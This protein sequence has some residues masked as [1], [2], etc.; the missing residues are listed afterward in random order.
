MSVTSD[1]GR[2]LTA[3]DDR[4]FLEAA[5]RLARKHQGLT[6]T[7]PSVSCLVVQMEEHGP[8]IVG[9][10]VTAIGG[11][12][13]AEP[14][15]LVQ[16][17]DRAAGATAYVTL[18]PCAHHGKTPPCAQTLID[19]KISRVVTAIGDPDRR[20]DGLGH[21]ILKD[22]GVEVTELDC[23]DLAARVI[24]GYLSWQRVGRPYITLKMAVTQ[25]GV[26]GSR[27]TGN[28]R[29]SGPVA[30]AQT[31]L[32]R[33]RS[34]AILIG[35]GT[36]VSD[37]PVL[38]CRLPGLEHRS[39]LRIVLDS[40]CKMTADLR[41]VKSAKE[42]ATMVVS[43]APADSGWKK[44]LAALGVV[45]QAC[46]LDG[47]HIALP[48]LVDD[49]G[50]QGIQTLLIEGGAEVA[51]SFLQENLVDE[52]L[53]HVGGAPEAEPDDADAVLAPFKPGMPPPG[54]E[55]REELEFGAD[56][57]IRLTREQS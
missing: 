33:A 43:P 13:H 57:A 44:D 52:I 56:R 19:A 37:D 22:A 20:V 17:G 46:E 7:N 25:N 47:N 50:A 49:L 9:T 32:A 26:I 34:D 23:G 21:K 30:R 41:L 42:V 8:V 39:P 3:E 6:G 27:R 31:H 38:T 53:M 45:H 14:P 10:G 35:S 16:A 28:F 4:R 5:L 54:F 55:V 24:K 48:E 40:S 1:K 36:A 12:P 11:R 2:E 15:A 18:E 29:I 51:A